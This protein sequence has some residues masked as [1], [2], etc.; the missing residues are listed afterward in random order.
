MGAAERTAA[1]VITEA[2]DTGDI[3]SVNTVTTTD[4]DDWVVMDKMEYTKFAY[5]FT[6]ADGTKQEA[7]CPGTDNKVYFNVAGVCT[8]IVLG[9]SANSTGGAV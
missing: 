9:T 4:V 1:N 8:F 5:A 7:Y 3:L 2:L 6:T